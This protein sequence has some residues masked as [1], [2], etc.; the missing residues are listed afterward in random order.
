MDLILA[1]IVSASFLAV[2]GIVF[3][4]GQY[5]QTR[6][7]LRRRLPA[8]ATIADS[9]APTP[10]S[11]LG[12]LVPEQ[13]SENRLVD[14][15]LR[16]KLRR[17]LVRA[18]FFSPYAIRYYIFFRFCTVVVLPLTVFVV[19]ELLLP[20][21]SFILRML[22]VLLAAGIGVLGPDAYLSRRQ[23]GLMQEYRLI[24]PDLL[25]LLNVCIS[26]GLSVEASFDRV[27]DHF[28]KRS[29]SLGRN[30]EL[31]GAEMRAGRSTVEAL[32]SF[33]DRLGL[34][35]AAAF[36]AVLRHSVELGGDIAASLHVFS[37]DMR[38]KR[39]LIAEKKANELPVK[40]VIP[41]A[42]GIFPVI[43][44]IVLLPVIMKLMQVF[45]V[46]KH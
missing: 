36:V 25:D 23:T 11:A 40:M 27:R 20:G 28:A 4:A 22:V 41:L 13:F 30:I 24:F 46:V 32:N 31:M 1:L 44:T 10:Q 6:A 29:R 18:G 26:A 12:M 5:L 35:E 14:S 2:A 9:G 8:G 38:V 15:N 34:D 17:E 33:A 7:D 21:F 45:S 16:Q 42:L 37:E 19:S 43:L 39:M 3:V